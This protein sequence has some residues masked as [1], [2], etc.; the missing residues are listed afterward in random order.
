M[1]HKS[2][3][4]VW[5]LAALVATIAWVSGPA[6]AE[7][8]IQRVVSPGGIVAWLVE[9]RSNP[10]ISMEI[11][12][13]GGAIRDPEGK[14]GLS[15]LMSATL[16]EG[17]GDLSSQS[18]RKALN[19]RAIEI[20]F[21]ASRDTFQGSVKTL[22]MNRDRA[23]ELL[24]LA[25]TKPRFDAEPVARMQRDILA[26]I[27]RNNEQPGYRASSAW[28]SLAFGDAGYGRPL[29]G[30]KQQVT[31]L[32]PQDLRA[33]HKNMLTRDTMKIAVVGDID[34]PTLAPLLDATF[35][36][37]PAKSG[38]AA[39]NGVAPRSGPAFRAIAMNVPQTALRFGFKG[40]E[41]DDPDFVAAYIMN[42]ILGGG[43]FSSRLYSEVREKRGL[44]YSVSSTLYP[45]EGTG[46]F[47]GGT[48]SRTE[49]AGESLKVIRA[50]LQRMA[51]SGPTAQELA[52]AK[53]FLTGAYP[54]RFDTNTKIA[55]QLV[56]IQTQNLGID[57]INIR[58]GLINSVT[59]DDVQRVARRLLKP[60]ALIVTAAGRPASLE[61]LKPDS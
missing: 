11:A 40:L 34:A 29:R 23:F 32:G 61:A 2:S 31:G 33:L 46:I 53:T 20:S 10:I 41:R 14:S 43:S 44:S 25:L 1:T 5:L 18:F 8:K 36:D 28:Y 59:L 24:K 47:I 57:Y 26:M 39:L 45:L 54:L 9:E 12:F 4:P 17:A 56:G 22:T 21:D 49:R 37:L 30:T 13:S 50:E 19:D 48:A 3:A 38:F 51:Q 27:A 15:Y 35:G 52:A 6:S 7:V 42:H 58:N 55:N 60:G 16:D